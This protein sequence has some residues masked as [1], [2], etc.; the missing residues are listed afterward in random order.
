M[1]VL[2]PLPLNHDFEVQPIE[3]RKLDLLP[4]TVRQTFRQT[5]RLLPTLQCF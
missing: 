1:Y 2:T 5:F 4:P 3:L